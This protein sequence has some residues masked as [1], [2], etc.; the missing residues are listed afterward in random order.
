MKTFGENFF[1]KYNKGD[2][3][4]YELAPG[5]VIQIEAEC[6]TDVRGYHEQIGIIKC[7]PEGHDFFKEGDR[8]LTHYLASDKGNEIEINKEIYHRVTLPQIFLKINEDDSFTLAEDIYLCEYSNVSAVTES[9]I[10][11]TFTGEKK[12]DL[13]LIV[14]NLPSSINKRWADDPINVGDV[15]MPQDNY[16]YTFTYKKKEYVKIEHKFIMGVYGNKETTA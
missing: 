12:E 9:G 7:A 11:T 8:V 14:T 13:K 10:L 2:I 15:L 5:V 4:N 1:I 6:N 3:K 16:N